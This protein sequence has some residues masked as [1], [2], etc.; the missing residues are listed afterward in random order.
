MVQQ[1]VL[2]NRLILILKQTIKDDK[3]VATLCRHVI[4]LE[5]R[6]FMTELSHE[7]EFYA[8]LLE[9]LT[10]HTF[11]DTKQNVTTKLARQWIIDERQFRKQVEQDLA[12]L[13]RSSALS[14]CQNLDNYPHVKTSVVNYGVRN[15][16]ETTF[17]KNR[18]AE[19]QR[20]LKEVILAFEPR[21]V[22][23]SL[24]LT[25]I[26]AEEIANIA[27]LQ[28]EIKSNIIGLSVPLHLKAKLDLETSHI[29]IIDN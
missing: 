16:I 5:K 2:Q 19:L 8:S 10:D 24:S 14:S 29:K 3:D 15:R 23:K 22:K 7:K 6:C 20:H 13:L 4:F 21:I 1:M 9:R 18:T 26:E 27:G 17:S 12:W 28:F 11:S 25:K